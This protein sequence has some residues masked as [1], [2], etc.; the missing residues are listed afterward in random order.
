VGLLL[1]ALVCFGIGAI[2]FSGLI[3]R[4]DE[5]GRVLFGVAWGTLG[6]V[7]LGKYLLH[8]RG[9]G[10]SDSGSRGS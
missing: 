10:D 7:W 3:L 1:A 9:T 2:S 4:Q 5:L 8:G 6:V